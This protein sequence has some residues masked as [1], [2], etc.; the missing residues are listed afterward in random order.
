MM[1]YIKFKDEELF[2]NEFVVMTTPDRSGSALA[3]HQRLAQLHQLVKKPGA[4]YEQFR[5]LKIKN[6]LLPLKR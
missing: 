5:S 4:A 3:M 1:A 6:K 2:P